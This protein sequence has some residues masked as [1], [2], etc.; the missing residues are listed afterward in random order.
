MSDPAT[1]IS[2]TSSEPPTPEAGPGLEDLHRRAVGVKA[3]LGGRTPVRVDP[4]PAPA[5][6][7]APSTS[8]GPGALAAVIARLE[9]LAARHELVLRD[10]SDAVHRLE[11]VA[12]RLETISA[13]TPPSQN[14]PGP[15]ADAI[16]EAIRDAVAQPQPTPATTTPKPKP[17][18]RTRASTTR[19]TTRKKG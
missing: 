4:S 11:R 10:A 9:H 1:N 14:E 15:I 18:P 8:A 13:E 6:A 19:K 3:L 12:R 17:K 7:P 5:P 2:P 16:R